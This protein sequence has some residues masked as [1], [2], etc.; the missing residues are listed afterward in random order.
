MPVQVDEE[1]CTGCKTCE[2]VC[3]MQAITVNEKAKVNPDDCVECGQCVDE[4]PEGA[5]SL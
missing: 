1:K 2:E 5:L 3:P 4:C